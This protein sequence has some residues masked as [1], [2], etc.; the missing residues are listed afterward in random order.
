MTLPEILKTLKSSTKP[1]SLTL[2][3]TLI[4]DLKKLP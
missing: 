3:K 1:K 2:L 4:K